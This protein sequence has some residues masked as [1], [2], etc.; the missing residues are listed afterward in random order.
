MM[1]FLF[2]YFLLK[3][4]FFVRWLDFNACVLMYF[5]FYPVC[6]APHFAALPSSKGCGHVKST[7]SYQFEMSHHHNQEMM[8]HT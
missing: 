8:R 3:S 4:A 5:L 1:S 6:I 2:I 7:T